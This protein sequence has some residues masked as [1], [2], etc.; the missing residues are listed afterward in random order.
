Y[1]WMALGWFALGLTAKPM[2]VTLPFVLLL[3]DFWPLCR[4]RGFEERVEEKEPAPRKGK[5]GQAPAPAK[6]SSPRKSAADLVWEKAAF[7]ALSI[8]SSVMT[9]AETLPLTS[10]LANAMLSYAR[11]LGKMVW[12]TDLAVIYPH[13]GT[14]PLAQVL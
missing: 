3:L 8:L 14:W 4:L 2:L 1:W 13:P 7:F 6:K 5:R 10:R 9:S 12:P 11:Y